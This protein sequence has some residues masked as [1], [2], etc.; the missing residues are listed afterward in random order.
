MPSLEL[1]LGNIF[2]VDGFPLKL[3]SIPL[4]LVTETYHLLCLSLSLCF[5]DL[6][7]HLFGCDLYF[8]VLVL[9][10]FIVDLAY[11]AFVWIELSLSA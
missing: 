4:A 5:W 9:R 10:D 2:F 1:F 3:E 7:Y 8:W 11:D 6:P